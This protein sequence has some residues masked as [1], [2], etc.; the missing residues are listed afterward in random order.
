MTEGGLRAYHPLDHS[1]RPSLWSLVGMPERGRRLHE[2]ISNG[3]PFEAVAMLAEAMGRCQADIAK[4]L[5]I[6]RKTL[7]RRRAAG[8]LTPEESDRLYRLLK[9]LAAAIELFEGDTTAAVEWLEAPAV[10]LSGLRPVEMT[11]ST[12]E[13]DAVLDLVAR[14]EL[15]GSI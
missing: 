9:V 2:F 13:T 11:A 1:A 14:L 10:G 15:G 6:S 5:G 3:A 4:S 12:A 7:M 8:R